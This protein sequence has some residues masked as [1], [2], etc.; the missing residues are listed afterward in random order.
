VLVVTVETPGVVA[1]VTGELV[2]VLA[3]VEE[4]SLHGYVTSTPLMV[5]VHCGLPGEVV[6]TAT[7]I[8]LV[9]PPEELLSGQFFPEKEALEDWHSHLS[10]T[11]PQREKLP[12]TA[13][14][15][16]QAPAPP[17][18]AP[19]PSLVTLTVKLPRLVPSRD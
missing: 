7:G 11:H 14:S 8:V 9:T 12:V 13:Q 3:V 18:A 15:P 5:P 19:I 16:K 4:T 10:P 17:A 1:V 2:A 6:V